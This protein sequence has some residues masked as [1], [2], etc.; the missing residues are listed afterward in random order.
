MP[1]PVFFQTVEET[2]DSSNP[3]LPI[4]KLSTSG[5]SG[6]GGS[7]IQHY[8]LP[9]DSGGTIAVGNHVGADNSR[10]FNTR[11]DIS[12]KMALL[13]NSHGK[14]VTPNFGQAVTSS[15]QPFNFAGIALTETQLVS[16]N[17]NKKTFTAGSLPPPRDLFGMSYIEFSQKTI[18]FG[19]ENNGS[20]L[21]DTWSW[22][23]ATWAQINPISSPSSRKNFSMTY[24]SVRKVIVLFGGINASNAFLNDTWEFNG[25]NWS[26]IFPGTSPSTR[27][28]YA[29]KYDSAR[30]KTILFGGRNGTTIYNDTWEYNGTTWTNIVTATSPDIRFQHAMAFDSS[31]NKTILFGGL[32]VPATST[33]VALVNALAGDTTINVVD[34][35]SFPTAGIIIIGNEFISYTGKTSSTFTGCSHGLYNTSPAG[36]NIGVTVRWLDTYGDTWE[37]N[38]TN[39]S[40]I[41]LA[42]ALPPVRSGAKLIYNSTK[43]NT[44]LFA[45]IKESTRN[46]GDLSDTWTYDGNAWTQINVFGPSPRE[47]FGMTYD[48]N[49]D[50]IV[51][52]GGQNVS[53]LGANGETWEFGS[54]LRPVVVQ[55]SGDGLV[56]YDAS[57]GRPVP[58][59]GDFLGPSSIIG[60]VTPLY[61]GYSPVFGIAMEPPRPSITI[62]SLDITTIDTTIS[63]SSTTGF[64]T[65]GTIIIDHEQITYTGIT[66]TT[67][68][69]CIRAANSTV[70]ANH[71]LGAT[72][73][74]TIPLIFTFNGSTVGIIKMRIR[75]FY[76][77]IPP[78]PPAITGFLPNSAIVGDVVTLNGSVFIGTT[79][80]TINSAYPANATFN[81]ISNNQIT[82]VVPSGAQRGT[83]TITNAQG[84]STSSSSF[85]TLPSIIGQPVATSY[86]VGSTVAIYGHTFTYV[87]SV[88]F[89]GTSAS[90]TLQNDGYVTAIIPSGATNGN[91]DLTIT[92]PITLDTHTAT[93]PN[94]VIVTVP[95][96]TN[97][98]PLSGPIGGYIAITGT[99]FTVAPCTVVLIDVLTMTQ[100]LPASRTV[101]NDTTISVT[102]PNPGVPQQAK[103]YYVRITTNGGSVLSSQQYTIIPVPKF[104]ASPG[105]TFSPIQGPAGTVVDILGDYGFTGVS[106]VQFNG[107][108]SPSVTFISDTHITAVVPTVASSVDITGPIRVTGLGGTKS[109]SESPA[110]LPVN[111]TIQQSPTI[112]AISD[113]DPLHDSVPSGK[114]N[115]TV[116][117]TGTNLL[118]V[119][120]VIFTTDGYATFSI[121][122][123]T[124]I[125]AVVPVIGGV[126]SQ[127]PIK[128]TKGASPPYAF[129]ASSTPLNFL[130][131]PAPSSLALSS[132]AVDGGGINGGIGTLVT[133]TGSNLNEGG[134]P[135]VKFGTTPAIPSSAGSGSVTVTV[136]SAGGA[137]PANG[138]TLTTAGGT[139]TT[140]FIIQQPVSISS[141]SPTSVRINYGGD[142]VHVY[143]SNFRPSPYMTVYVTDPGNGS[144]AVYVAYSYVNSGHI[145]FS[146]TQL[147][148]VGGFYPDHPLYITAVTNYPGGTY[149]SYTYGLVAYYQIG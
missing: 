123:S 138:I 113:P 129:I 88:K 118:G 25:T 120:N 111:F 90:Y 85:I 32:A 130:F 77:F 29:M 93:Y 19:G 100:I 1:L 109:T 33:T 31:R 23:G 110:T 57:P 3:N 22:D 7:A 5:S 20:A 18:I 61:D 128:V 136:P 49:R 124:T 74:S 106:D 58:V 104:L 145:T 94:F 9:E 16:D 140:S 91:L 78:L 67:F 148:P 28:D 13:F 99:G 6:F 142:T 144:T 135:I 55:T 69:G 89:N 80:V 47:N 62:L 50:R 72:V 10:I 112:T 117:I 11:T 4:V 87:T 71:T 83:I 101:Y 35:S 52:F 103:A 127:G 108:S 131:Y 126:Q 63:V 102:V 115:D 24:D 15:N 65:S 125:N 27:S 121:I 60:T 119:T 133:L 17:W 81:I 75:P 137:A 38:G 37:Y 122:N 92:Y 21:G 14:Y 64:L 116:V 146:S 147:G 48:S 114:A 54:P 56:Y 26:Q 105:P 96:I 42:G 53:I 68:T 8:I 70:A 132:P 139:V 2:I 36:H 84:N 95:T 51:L 41:F 66:S 97:V 143:G 98:A 79:Q 82:F 12:T 73:S 76:G 45:G 107:N 46:K 39:W 59:T 141:F 34:T 149:S 30:A 86:S 44:M 134:T 43:K 40:Q